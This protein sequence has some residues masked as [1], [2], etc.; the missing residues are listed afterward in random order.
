MLN[1]PDQ[2]TH[3]FKEKGYPVVSNI[4]V[5]LI[6]TDTLRVL[7]RH[8]SWK[9]LHSKSFNFIL[10]AALPPAEAKVNPLAQ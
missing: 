10:G 4:P 6:L 2:T 5:V 1:L 9:D 3:F 7:L 8:Q